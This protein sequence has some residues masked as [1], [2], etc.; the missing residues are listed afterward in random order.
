MRNSQISLHTICRLS[1]ILNV[2]P[3]ACNWCPYFHLSHCQC[4]ILL[5]LLQKRDDHGNSVLY[6]K[7]GILICYPGH[8][9][10][11]YRPHSFNQF[12]MMQAFSRFLSPFG[13][14]KHFIYGSGLIK[15]HIR[16]KS[17]SK[18]GTPTKARKLQFLDPS[19]LG[20][21]P[22]SHHISW[23]SMQ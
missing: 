17:L 15:I 23:K 2:Q 14:F 13:L 18:V 16:R 19:F 3:H 20:S 1:C 21:S 10:T 22:S 7:W 4:I 11:N 9:Y 6:L 5:L 12:N 8:K